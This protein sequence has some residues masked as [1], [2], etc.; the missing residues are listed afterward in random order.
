MTEDVLGLSGIV[1]GGL[2]DKNHLARWNLAVHK[3][4]S[5]ADRRQLSRKD[6]SVEGTVQCQMELENQISLLLWNKMGKLQLHK[7]LRTSFGR[8]VLFLNHVDPK[9][10]AHKCPVGKIT[11]TC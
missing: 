8:F 5:H 6:H 9:E 1:A 10:G 2:D 3:L 4:Q 11:F 7:I